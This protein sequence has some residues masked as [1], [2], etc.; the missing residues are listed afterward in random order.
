MRV[1][2]VVYPASESRFPQG[3]DVYNGWPTVAITK[4]DYVCPTFTGT[5]DF[6]TNITG[7]STSTSYKIA[8]VWTDGEYW[9]SVVEASF[10]TLAPA[11]YSI[12]V[13]SAATMFNVTDTTGYVRVTI[14]IT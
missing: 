6:P 12:P 14:T 11:G 5:F 10:T 13:L 4:G 3:L 2:Y 9:S 1:F 8:F 7:L